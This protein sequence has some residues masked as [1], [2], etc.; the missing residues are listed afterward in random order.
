MLLPLALDRGVCIITN[1]GASKRTLT[2]VLH[3]CFTSLVL[4][5]HLDIASVFP[6]H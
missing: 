5:S 3:I 4:F 1:M 2:V 6:I